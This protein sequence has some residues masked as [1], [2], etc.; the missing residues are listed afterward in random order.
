MLKK[1][2]SSTSAI[3]HTNSFP[4]VGKMSANIDD[5]HLLAD[6]GNKDAQRCLAEAYLEGLHGLV[7]S[8]W[9]SSPWRKAADA[10]FGCNEYGQAKNSL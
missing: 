6:A 1:S 5:I 7:K 8:P 2:A 4:I 10:T 3:P 9:M